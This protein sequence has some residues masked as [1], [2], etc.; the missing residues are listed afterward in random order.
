M[1][2]DEGAV[3]DRA[4]GLKY[5]GRRLALMADEG[6]DVSIEAGTPW[7]HST[8][9][10]EHQIIGLGAVSITTG[11]PEATLRTL[12]EIM[13]FTII[14]DEQ[15][16]ESPEHR[17]VLLQIHTGG[18]NG[19][20]ASRP[21]GGEDLTYTRQHLYL[22]LV[23]ALMHGISCFHYLVVFAVTFPLPS[24]CSTLCLPRMVV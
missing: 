8:V 24:Q 21:K 9:P 14:A 11:R 22:C 18:P 10:A 23:S 7:E 3:Q 12:T 2:V 4:L 15:G 16:P 17:I 6:G 1:D 20:T 19:L 13:G 5:T